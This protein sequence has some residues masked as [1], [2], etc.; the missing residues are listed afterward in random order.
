MPFVCSTHDMCSKY[1][2]FGVCVHIYV[3]VCNSVFVTVFKCS[4]GPSSSNNSDG[5]VVNL[6][7]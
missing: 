1:S 5:G 2:I 3:C 4:N 7:K 6:R